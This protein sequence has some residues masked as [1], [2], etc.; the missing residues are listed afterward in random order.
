M[1]TIDCF[2]PYAD[3]AIAKGIV[4]DLRQSTYVKNIFLLT[5]SPALP[6]LEGCSTIFI[7]KPESSATLRQI[8]LMARADYSLL[9]NK[10]TP[11]SIG[12]H[13][14]ERMVRTA[15]LNKAG[16]VYG[17]RYEVKNG[18]T[19]R[20]QVIP[21]QKGSVRNDFDFGSLRL[22]RTECI[23]SWAEQFKDNQWNSAALYELT[24]SI[25][26]IFYLNEYLYTEQEM[27]VRKSGEKQ[28]DY[29][30]PR[31]RDV[32]I[33][34]EQVCTQHLKRI[35]AYVSPES[36]TDIPIENGSFEYEAS[37]IIPVRN[38]MKT[39]EDAIMSALS[40]RTD[41]P[42]NIIVVDNHSTDGTTKS[43]R[44]VANFDPRVVH[45]IPQRTDLGIGGC[46]DLA[47]NDSRCG[48]FAIQLD[49]DDLYSRPDTLQII[50]DM[51][52]K[53]HCAMVIGS[54]RMCDF[55]LKTLPP[56]IIDHREW[57]DEN[58]RNNALRINGLGA[59]RAFFTP[60][61]RQVGFPNTSYGEDYAL[62][63]AFSRQY[64][65]GRIYEELYLCRRWDGNSDAA[66]SVEKINAN[67][68][69]KDSLRTIE[70]EARQRMNQY[71]AAP[72]TEA[73]TFH[74]QQLA[75]WPDAARRYKELADV[76]VRE[77]NVEGKVLK[78]QFNPSRIVSTGSK[79]DPKTISHRTCFLC[80]MNRPDEQISQAVLGRYELLVNP[81][82][83]LPKHF[84]IA[85]RKHE[86]QTIHGHYADMLHIADLMPCMMVFYNGPHCGASAPDHMHFQAVP[87][88][89]V[90]PV[91]KHFV[92]RTST[93]E[94]SEAQFAQY[95]D[96][97]TNI[98]V[99]KDAGEYVTV[100]I[101]RRK[102]RPECYGTADDQY[103]VSPGALDM[104]GLI[105]TPR[106]E[107]FQ[108]LTPEA[109][110]SILKECG[111]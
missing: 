79:I 10:Y 32:Q 17:D 92:I 58:G 43:I 1:K 83:I 3:E 7:D 103:L 95:E 111:E 14:L 81:F 108:R 65:I 60:L 107:D 46:W 16:M 56:G 38:R 4:E 93:I 82:P 27:D 94:E 44:K 28:F 22:Y 53:E 89:D 21:F 80:L 45:I 62:G 96:D 106:L 48:R 9:Y 99:W 55:N 91:S 104:A 100:V 50:V 75:K 101:P 105:I 85:S 86:P 39:I 36:I 102:H 73:E 47:I 26:S 24:L 71:L 5:K 12:Y 19:E 84:T 61:L 49:S 98:L 20:H 29:V 76:K 59:P 33:E 87:Q 97:E 67:N 15:E 42:F 35:G 2:I 30:D 11:L 13:T 34:M 6:Q 68:Y 90:N 78:I 54:Y 70:I 51:F 63:L 23:K 88:M 77:V 41:F 57:T 8:A 31:N 69:Y 109:I 74:A 18:V 40:Q 66:L 110:A 52:R 37:V 64:K 25:D 72:F